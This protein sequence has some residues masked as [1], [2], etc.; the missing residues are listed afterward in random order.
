MVCHASAHNLEIGVYKVAS[1][2]QEAQNEKQVAQAARVQQEVIAVPLPVLPL[3]APPSCAYITLGRFVEVIV[4][5]RAVF[6]LWFSILLST[7]AVNSYKY[8]RG[9]GW[10]TMKATVN[11]YVRA[12]LCCTRADR[13]L[14]YACVYA[15]IGTIA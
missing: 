2:V 11:A 13:S 10:S 7:L 4:E 5:M 14:Q 6:V 1:N 15:C 12:E 8:L 3:A 9:N